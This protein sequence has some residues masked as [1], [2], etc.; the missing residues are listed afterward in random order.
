MTLNEQKAGYWQAFNTAL[1]CKNGFG[2]KDRWM[3]GWMDGQIDGQMD[4][5]L[6]TVFLNKKQEVDLFQTH[7]STLLKKLA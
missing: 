3:D 6:K 4:R 5:H 2:F 1:T 7:G